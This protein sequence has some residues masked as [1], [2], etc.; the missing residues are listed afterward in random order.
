LNRSFYVG[1][2]FA[3]VW[4]PKRY[5]VDESARH[6]YGHEESLAIVLAKTLLAQVVS[7]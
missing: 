2:K 1:Q 3:I 5:L 7:M 6:E 4:L